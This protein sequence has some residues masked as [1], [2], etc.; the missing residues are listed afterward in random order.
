MFNSRTNVPR[1][2]EEKVYQIKK[3]EKKIGTFFQWE[4]LVFYTNSE[5]SAIVLKCPSFSRDEKHLQEF[6]VGMK[7]KEK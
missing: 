4:L 3:K 7:T 5:W 6:L 1:K 2:Y